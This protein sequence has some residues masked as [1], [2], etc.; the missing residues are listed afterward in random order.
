MLETTANQTEGKLCGI[1]TINHFGTSFF[2]ENYGNLFNHIGWSNCE[3]CRR[4]GVSSNNL[5][6]KFFVNGAAFGADLTHR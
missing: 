2:T 4:I 1:K 5:D 3:T 6:C